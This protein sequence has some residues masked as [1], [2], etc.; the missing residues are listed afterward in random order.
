MKVLAVNSTKFFDKDRLN[1]QIRLALIRYRYTKGIFQIG[2]RYE[3]DGTIN[4][5]LHD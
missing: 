3:V 4:L 1:N 2:D 5:I